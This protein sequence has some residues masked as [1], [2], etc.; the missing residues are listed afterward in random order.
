[1]IINGGVSEVVYNLDYFHYDV[2]Q[3]LLVEA[4]VTCRQ[5]KLGESK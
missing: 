1:M 4:E 2:A 5:L 3:K